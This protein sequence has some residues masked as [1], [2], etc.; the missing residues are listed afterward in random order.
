MAESRWPCRFF[1]AASKSSSTSRS[2]RYSR[3]RYALLARRVGPTARFSAFGTTSRKLGFAGIFPPGIRILLV[4]ELLFE[5]SA[6]AHNGGPQLQSAKYRFVVCA[7]FESSLL[8]VRSLRRVHLKSRSRRERFDNRSTPPR[9]PQTGG[10][11][12][13]RSPTANFDEF[14]RRMVDSLL[15]PT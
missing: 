9:G 3:V 14:F 7:R 4:D 8:M 13:P 11:L 15:T 1:L 5:Q 6:Y 12:T 10:P 2:V